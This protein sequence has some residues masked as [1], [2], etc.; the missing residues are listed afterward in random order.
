MARLCILPLVGVLLS[1]QEPQRRDDNFY[2]REKEA[3]LGASLASE[4]R[5]HTS[6]LADSTVHDYI[7]GVG[8]RLA[9][10]VRNGDLDWKWA[11]I[12]DRAGGSTQEPLSVPGGYIFVSTSLILAV[13]N[14]AELAGML[15]H[16]MAHIAERHG[17][18][19]AARGQVG[20]LSSIPLVFLGGWMGRGA[21]GNDDRA[22]VPVGYLK[23]QRSNE[24]D[25]DRVA[26]TIMAAAGYDPAALVD[27]IRRTQRVL[28]AESGMYSALPP[29]EERI[30]ALETAVANLFPVPPR[31]PTLGPGPGSP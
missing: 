1:A 31:P 25:A 6:A 8:R 16:S 20:N 5:K 13:K 14:E 2:S 12:R 15:A 7:E 3:A 17:T 11:V 27:Y 18:R 26:V 30:T 24:L 19:M 22:F 4:V 21:A 10:K 29:R 28:T 23:I 9:A